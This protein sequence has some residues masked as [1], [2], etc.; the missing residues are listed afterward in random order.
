MNIRDPRALARLARI[1]GEAWLRD[2][3]RYTSPYSFRGVRAV[4]EEAATYLEKFPDST[5]RELASDIGSLVIYG[6]GGWQRYGLDNACN[7]V[8]LRES[9]SSE[10]KFARAERILREGE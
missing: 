9:F 7:I 3:Q 10:E 5:L 1:E 8:P 2:Q 6:A 4:V